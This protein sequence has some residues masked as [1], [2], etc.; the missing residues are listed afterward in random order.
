LTLES[1][2]AAWDGVVEEIHAARPT[3]AASLKEARPSA[4]RDDGI[5]LTL[6]PHAE[7]RLEQLSA[8]GMLDP[9]A[10]VLERRWGFGGRIRVEPAGPP[11][12]GSEAPGA[13]GAG[14]KPRPTGREIEAGA[15][16]ARLKGDPLLRQ[17]VD[18]FDASVVRV[19]PSQ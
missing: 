17:V 2:L 12:A 4:C 9:L 5:T 3:V 18:L 14:R 8:R 11:E 16:D 7:F 1:L 19:K 13:A 10:G 15:I 6:P